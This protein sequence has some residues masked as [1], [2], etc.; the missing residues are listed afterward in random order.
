MCGQAQREDVRAVVR[1][2]ITV[3]SAS[4]CSA[5]LSLEGASLV[6]TSDE[7]ISRFDFL[8]KVLDAFLQRCAARSAKRA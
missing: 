1:L 6:R 8:K 2:S 7:P 3:L 4:T 5:E